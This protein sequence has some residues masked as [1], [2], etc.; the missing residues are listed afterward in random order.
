LFWTIQEPRGVHYGLLNRIF[1][2]HTLRVYSDKETN[3]G[4]GDN[5]SNNSNSL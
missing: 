5:T 1:Y 2:W 4:D 3:D